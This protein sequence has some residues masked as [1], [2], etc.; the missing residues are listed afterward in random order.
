MLNNALPPPS[1]VK[2][3]ACRV[4]NRIN[5]VH[6]KFL[7]SKNI[8]IDIKLKEGVLGDRGLQKESIKIY[9]GKLS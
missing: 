8:V 1:F 5:T 4:F 7:F 6:V 9:S 2:C 3:N